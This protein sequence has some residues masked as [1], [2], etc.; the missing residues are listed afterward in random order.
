M[1]TIRH[2]LPNIFEALWTTTSDKVQ[3]TIATGAILSPFW[4]QWL[5]NIS[6]VAALLMPI[7]GLALIGVNIVAAIVK[8]RKYAALN[9]TMR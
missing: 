3:T 6:D 7:F 9:R 4:L 2:H 5:K 1:P 8:T